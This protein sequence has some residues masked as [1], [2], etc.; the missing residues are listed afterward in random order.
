MLPF[1][2]F[3]GATST[4]LTNKKRSNNILKL[5]SAWL[6]K[7]AVTIDDQA[8]DLIVRLVEALLKA[9]LG[10]KSFVGTKCSTVENT[11][12]TFRIEYVTS[13]K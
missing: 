8:L 4:V 3:C 1:S 11:Q 2:S 12:S 5:V 13:T 10:L 6:N 7:L 9:L